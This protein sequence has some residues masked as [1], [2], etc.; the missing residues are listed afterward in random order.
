MSL[1][2][3]KRT[4]TVACEVEAT[5]SIK[6][7]SKSSKIPDYTR[8][9]H[10]HGWVRTYHFEIRTTKVFIPLCD[11]HATMPLMRIA[12]CFDGRINTHHHIFT[13]PL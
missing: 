12:V 2:R 8:R 11:K 1:N 10:V 6:H 7:I 3:N 13:K 5:K 4:V 9:A